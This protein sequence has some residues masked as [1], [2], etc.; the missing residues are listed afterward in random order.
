ML[1]ERAQNP[2][3]PVAAQGPVVFDTTPIAFAVRECVPGFDLA[4]VPQPGA[5]VAL[6]LRSSDAQQLHDALVAAGTPITAPPVDSPFG[7][8]F[9]F[10]DPDGYVVTIHDTP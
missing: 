10:A 6:W 2:T 5:G 9:S 3:A 7:R 4:T 1:L 8:T